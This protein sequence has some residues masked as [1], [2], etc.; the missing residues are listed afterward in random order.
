MSKIKQHWWNP[1]DPYSRSNVGD[2]GGDDG[3]SSPPIPSWGAKALPPF[4]REV[5]RA[6]QM[7]AQLLA[8]DWAEE[9][10]K[11]K[12]SWRGAW[13]EHRQSLRERRPH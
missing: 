2:K 8:R 11:L 1:F 7:D 6:G 12:G 13:L 3:A 4:L 5:R 10:R 9:D